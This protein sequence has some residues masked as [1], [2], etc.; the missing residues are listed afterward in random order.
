LD[1]REELLP[2]TFCDIGAV[3]LF[4]RITPWQ[5]PGFDLAG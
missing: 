1:G 2:G 5:I 4:P 3:A